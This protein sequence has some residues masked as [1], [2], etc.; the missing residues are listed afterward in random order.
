M[1]AASHPEIPDNLIDAMC[2]TFWNSSNKDTIKPWAELRESH[3]D[4]DR[5]SMRAALSVLAA[6]VSDEMVEAFKDKMEP[7]TDGSGFNYKAALAAAIA[8]AGD[9]DRR[10]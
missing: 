9:E 7:Y 5:A 6:N 2:A 10:A 1:M 8:A 4:E 3:K